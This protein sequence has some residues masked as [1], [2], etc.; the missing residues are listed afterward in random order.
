MYHW[1]TDINADVGE[2]VGNESVIMPFLSSCNIACGG[3]AGDED[4]M[5][6]T[7]L[8][9]KKNKV[10]MGAHPSYPDPE[11]FGRKEIDISCAGLFSSIKS[12][13]KALMNIVRQEGRQLHH[14]KP[15]GALYNK[16]AV[17]CDTATIVLEAIKSFP[18]PLKLYVPY[19][20]VIASMAIEERIPI[21]YEAFADR[22]YRDDLTLVPRSE[23]NAIITDLDNMTEHVLRMIKRGVVKTVNGNEIPIQ[24]DTFCVHG[25][26]PEAIKLLQGLRQVLNQEFVKIH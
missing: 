1:V 13:I 2:G 7:V 26:N 4:T 11:N 14:V 5:K 10:K 6:M 21:K 18:M 25:D 16:A 20:S 15:H 17:D 22:N 19:G 8:E 9:A 3:H 12:Q 23:P 24:A